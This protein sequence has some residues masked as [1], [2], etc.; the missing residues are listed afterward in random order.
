MDL[1]FGWIKIYSEVAVAL[2]V[3]A[4]LVAF[5]T[6]F[7]LDSL[8][9]GSLLK[10]S[11]LLLALGLALPVAWS[12]APKQSL[13]R[14]SLQVFS[15]TVKSKPFRPLQGRIQA[16]AVSGTASPMLSLDD[17]TLFY[18]ALAS[19]VWVLLAFLRI[20][21]DGVRTVRGL[22]LLPTLRRHRRAHVL[23]SDDGCVPFAARGLWRVYVVLP[24][25]FLEAPLRLRMSL[26]HE[27]AH[28]KHGDGIALWILEFLQRA[29][30]WNPA[31]GILRRNLRRLQEFA[32]DEHVVG[33]RAY[34]PQVYGSC[35]LE[36]AK[37]ATSFHVA[38]VG[39]TG[40]AW[41]DGG[42][43]LKR[44]ITMILQENAHRKSVPA[45]ATLL[46]A[47]TVAGCSYFTRSAVQ[48]R[49][50][51]LAEASEYARKA[52]EKSQVPVDMND[53]VLER[54]NRL[55]GT[56]DGRK[57]VVEAFGRLPQ[58]QPMIEEKFASHKVPGELVALALHESGLRNDATSSMRAAGIW[59]FIPTTARRYDLV[60]NDKIDERTHPEKETVAAA[61][62]LRDLYEQLGDW[63]LAA[64]AYNEGE[65]RVVKLIRE[66]G[67]RDPW[68]LERKSTTENY[69]S[70]A[71][72]MLILYQNPDLVAS[73]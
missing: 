3:V 12:Q 10:L 31:L 2:T 73:L 64:K 25:K 11:Y 32:C 49:R 17:K 50:L 40:M 30:F 43:E 20:L 34:S 61:R 56:P 60:V 54:L 21:S 46:L 57:H 9:A 65:G 58:Y 69:L 53:L 28:L 71:M 13:L 18:G 41:E 42:L 19:F 70:G 51:S 55:L 7:A 8:R 15:G 37:S 59:Q 36:A 35:L 44:R 63:R 38:P 23:V 47:L 45:V 6:H 14:P 24:R 4:L 48:E 5:V 68:Q 27:G 1:A 62:Y 26:R 33:H 16:V 66:Y 29:F 39:T 67:T 72:A 52:A 22:R